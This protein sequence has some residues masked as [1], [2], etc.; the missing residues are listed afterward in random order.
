MSKVSYRFSHGTLLLDDGSPDTPGVYL[1][2]RN[3]DLYGYP[4]E[5]E[6]EVLM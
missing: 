3:D 6:P 2:Q 1:L 5:V 4:L